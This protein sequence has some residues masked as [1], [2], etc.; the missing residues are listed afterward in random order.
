MTR[1]ARVVCWLLIWGTPLGLFGCKKK[2]PLDANHALEASFQTSEPQARQ[3]V[4]TLTN[5][6]RAGNYV[7]AARALEPLLAGRT[8]TPDQ[9]QAAGL[10]FRQINETIAANPSLDSKQLYE[11]RVK[12]AQAARGNKF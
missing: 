10:L 3:A 4:A 2:A 6:I 1:F 9:R 11:L 5:S 7:E 8:L 12:L